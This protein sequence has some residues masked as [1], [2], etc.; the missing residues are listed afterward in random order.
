[1]IVENSELDSTL[2]ICKWRTNQL[3]KVISGQDELIRSYQKQ[4][5]LKEQKE[6]ML[7]QQVIFAKK[8]AVRQTRRKSIFQ[9]GTIA[10]SIAIGSLLIL[11]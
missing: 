7:Q 4:I 8:E 3:K 6:R 1:M 9:I 10:S 2:S 11:K 5:M